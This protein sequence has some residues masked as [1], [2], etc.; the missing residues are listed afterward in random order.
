MAQGKYNAAFLNRIF[1]PR[2]LTN[3]RLTFFKEFIKF[4]SSLVILVCSHLGFSGHD[5]TL[6]FGWL[7]FRVSGLSFALCCCLTNCYSAGLSVSIS[8]CWTVGL[9]ICIGRSVCL[10]VDRWVCLC[11]SVGRLVP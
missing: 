4:L 9:F 1:A 10:S 6:S 8:D 3:I 2:C 7:S 11:W 5:N